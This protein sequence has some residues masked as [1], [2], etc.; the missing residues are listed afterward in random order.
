MSFFLTCQQPEVQLFPP[1][2]KQSV[3]FSQM[4]VVLVVV[5]HEGCLKLSLQSMHFT[6]LVLLGLCD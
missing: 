4:L 5:T 1:C 3:R 6:D 2:M